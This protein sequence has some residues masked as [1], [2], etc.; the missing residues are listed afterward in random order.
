MGIYALGGFEVAGPNFHEG[1]GLGALKALLED[2]DR[3]REFGAAIDESADLPHEDAVQ[4]PLGVADRVDVPG[5]EE[6]QRSKGEG[7]SDEGFA[8][9]PRDLRERAPGAGFPAAFP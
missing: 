6:D 5:R 2:V 1:A 4:V 7:A 8:V 9:L 3:V